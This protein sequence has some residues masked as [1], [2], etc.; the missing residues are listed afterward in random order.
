MQRVGH[1]LRRYAFVYNVSVLRNLIVGTSGF[2]RDAQFLGERSDNLRVALKVA[3]PFKYLSLVGAKPNAV[4]PGARDYF[5]RDRTSPSWS[6]D[7]MQVLIS[8]STGP[9]SSNILLTRDTISSAPRAPSQSSKTSAGCLVGVVHQWLGCLI[10]DVAVGYLIDVGAR[11]LFPRGRS[12][13]VP[14]V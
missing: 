11:A 5:E 7:W 8:P 3:E 9:W 10:D 1:S 13:S 14:P 12:P 2:D 6:R 4:E